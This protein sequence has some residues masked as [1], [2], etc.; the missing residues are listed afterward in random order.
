MVKDQA[1]TASQ[2]DVEAVNSVDQAIKS[3][4]ISQDDLE[5][6]KLFL[7]AAEEG[8]A[9]AQYK[10]GVMYEDGKGVKQDAVEAVKWYR[11]TTEQGDTGGQISLGIM[12]AK[13]RG[14]EQDQL[15]TLKWFR[16]AAEQGE[17]MA[18]L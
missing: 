16:K 9:K 14:V 8:N 15:E 18:Q 12:Y 1:K 11:K 4:P 17:P 13:G 5:M 7:K 2:G 6:Y 3:E 10:L